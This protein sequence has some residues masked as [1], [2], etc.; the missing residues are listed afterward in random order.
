MC[1]CLCVNDQLYCCTSCYTCV[2]C[3]CGLVVCVCVCVCDCTYVYVRTYICMYIYVHAYVVSALCPN[4]LF[5]YN[6]GVSFS[7]LQ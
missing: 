5:L 3:V 2:L 7:S 1:I 4:V 6:S